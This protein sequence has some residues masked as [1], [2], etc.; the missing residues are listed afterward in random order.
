MATIQR[1]ERS[2]HWYYPDGTACHTVT[3]KTTG[4][5]RATTVTDARKLGL[6]PSVTNILGMKAKPALNTWLQ[7]NAIL[8]ALSTPRKP[9]ESEEDWHFRIA[10]ES[11]RIGREAAEWG[12]LL[13][14]QIEGYCTEG[15]FPGTGEILAY[16]E[17]YARW[18]RENVVEVIA[19]EQT[20]V[21]PFLGYAGRLDLHARILHN[22]EPRRAIIDYKSQK[23]KGKPK[24]NFYKEWQMQLMAY[25]DCLPATEGEPDPLII[26]IIIPSDKPGAVQVKI[27]DGDNGMALAAF[28]ACHHLWCYEKGYT[29]A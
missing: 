24:G 16:V 2:S 25:A 14:A 28:K 18:H 19:A 7:D 11:D 29:P 22:G 1:N 17:D 8:S 5:P 6:V 23:L 21:N 15:A 26:S 13:H 4:L 3:A 12:T 27:W 10:E 9:G 20:V